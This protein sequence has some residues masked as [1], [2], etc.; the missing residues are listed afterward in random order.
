MIKC[1][2][3]LKVGEEGSVIRLAGSKFLRKKLMEMGVTEGSH[4]VVRRT[5]LGGDPIQISVRGYDLIL[6]LKEAKDIIIG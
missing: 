2:S 3:E 6:R 4:I 5:A 1:L